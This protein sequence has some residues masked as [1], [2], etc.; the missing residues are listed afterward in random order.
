MN[1]IQKLKKLQAEIV[2]FQNTRLSDSG[3]KLILEISKLNINE[4]IKIPLDKKSSFPILFSQLISNQKLNKQHFTL[5]YSMIDVL[6]CF[7]DLSLVEIFKAI[8]NVL[9]QFDDDLSLKLLQTAPTLLLKCINT[10]EIISSIFSISTSLIASTSQ[11]VSTAAFAATQ[12]MITILFESAKKVTIDKT[13]VRTVENHQFSHPLY[14]ISFLLL[15]DFA[16]MTQNKKPTFIRVET[17]SF[18]NELWDT[19]LISN[20]KFISN[21]PF[22]MKTVESTINL[23][24][25]TKNISLLCTAVRCFTEQIPDIITN[26]ISSVISDKSKIN[27]VIITFLRTIFIKRPNLCLLLEKDVISKLLDILNDLCDPNEKSPLLTL[28]MSQISVSAA[29]KIQDTQLFS[30]TFA[31]EFII[32]LISTFS[33]TSISASSSTISSPL[34]Q[35]TTETNSESNDNMITHSNSKTSSDKISAFN[36]TS[37]EIKSQHVFDRLNDFWPLIFTILMKGIRLCD[38]LYG[39]I[40]FR[41]Y[42]LLLSLSSQYNI[43]DFSAVLLRV[44]CSIVA[45]QKLNRQNQLP[46]ETLSNSL[47]HTNTEGLGFKKKRAMAYQLMLSLLYKTPQFFSKFYPRLFVSLGMYSRSKI[48]PNFT[49]NLELDELLKMCEVLSKGTPFCINFLKDVLLVNQ[50]RFLLIWPSLI[51]NITLLLQDKDTTDETLKLLSEIISHCFDESILII[52]ANSIESLD[53]KRRLTVLNLIR[54]ILG[55]SSNKIEKHW[56]AIL[57]SISPS[58]C[59]SDVELLGS[60]FA[61]LSIICN[62]N[63]QKLGENEMQKC[64]ST[65]FE[66]AAQRV[67][68][69]ISLSSLGLFWV[70]TP[71]IHQISRFWK[72]I[73]IEM[74]VFFNDSRSDVATCALRTFFSLLSSN[75][76]QMPSDIYDLLITSCFIPILMTFSTFVPDLW[77]VQ[78]LALL[79]MCHSACSLWSLFESNPQ[80]IS[81]F[82][83]LLVEKQQ[84]FMIS[85]DNQ[86]INVAA[87]QFYVEAFKCPKIESDLREAILLSFTNIVSHFVANQSSNSLVISNF[88]HF[89]MN[90]LPL[91]KKFLT[92]RQLQMWL[93]SIELISLSLP[94]VSFSNITAQRVLKSAFMLLPIEKVFCQQIIQMF[95]SVCAK[96]TSHFL[97]TTVYDMLGEIFESKIEKDDAI[98]FVSDCSSIFQFDEAS[99]FIQ[100]VINYQFS[101]TKENSN[102]YFSIFDKISGFDKFGN[103]AKKIIINVLPL[104]EKDLQIGFIDD[105]ASNINLLISVWKTLCDPESDQFN[106]DFT[107]SCFVRILDHMF[108]K[109]RTDEDEKNVLKILSFIEKVGKPSQGNSMGDEKWHIY[110]VIPYLIPLFNDERIDVKNESKKIF[111]EI[112]SD[113]GNLI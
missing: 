35:K 6:D 23:P 49:C 59:F 76:G 1:P 45:K 107:H 8:E 98:F 89:F 79:E 30:R 70:I 84:N 111:S 34:K 86:D 102:K 55:H 16:N 17:V 105:N 48:D 103:E 58:N 108:E 100:K 57:T 99:S 39:D 27:H 91:Q 94:S 7:D 73:L 43:N 11:T 109:L 33:S 14:A 52:F 72:R 36:S 51:G 104:I 28:T 31:V 3:K 93:D 87:L 88:G 68:I 74:L 15:R 4:S 60:A 90:N 24:I 21:F 63:F 38:P 95:C 25:T 96:T 67:D 20:C 5:I 69:N 62:D 53:K 66:F 10:F 46:I 18:V 82:W 80:F 50:E 32:I 77:S 65:V 81:N 54:S 37:I 78:Q 41:I 61:S 113:M 64:I 9:P 29:L 101:I 44:L 106:S 56:G 40:V 13:T 75:M 71:F 85:C 42:S 26:L 92:K 47:L 12:Q 19:I 22:L 97:R 2:K 110:G 112:Y 83:T